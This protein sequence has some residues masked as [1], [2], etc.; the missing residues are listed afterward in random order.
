MH[1]LQSQEREQVNCLVG[2]ELFPRCVARES[3]GRIQ[4]AYNKKS[5]R[6]QE[7]DKL[8]MEALGQ[9]VLKLISRSDGLISR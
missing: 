3:M 2:K 4:P 1:K 5:A 7:K 9:V 8:V 6:L